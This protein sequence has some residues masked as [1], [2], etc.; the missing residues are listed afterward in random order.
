MK[1]FAHQYNELITCF[2][3][4]LFKG[5]L[6]LGLGDSMEGFL[7][8]QGLWIKDFG[9]FVQK[10]SRRVA[11]H[12]ERLA[13]NSGRPFIYLNGAHRKEVLVQGMI[14]A[15]DLQEGLVCVMRAVEPCQS[16]RSCAR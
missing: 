11:E 8:Q 2:D 4:I 10:Q 16:F 5:H 15:E 12:A 1:R 9:K 6:P 14:E 3:R 13:E 7:A